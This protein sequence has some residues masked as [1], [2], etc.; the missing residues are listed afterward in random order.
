MDMKDIRGR[1][2]RVVL[3]VWKIKEACVEWAPKISILALAFL[4]QKVIVQNEMKRFD[5][6]FK[7]YT[8][9]TSSNDL[10]VILHSTK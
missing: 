5:L 10:P 3:I 1:R 4:L 2:H 6:I 9:P 8:Q 7:K